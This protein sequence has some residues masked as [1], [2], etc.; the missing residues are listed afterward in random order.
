MGE[1]N[2]CKAYLVRCFI[3]NLR[4]GVEAMWY[5]ALYVALE[6]DVRKCV[7]VRTTGWETMNTCRMRVVKM[8]NKTRKEEY[9]PHPEPLEGFPRDDTYA[10]PSSEFE[11]G[12]RPTRRPPNTTD[13]HLTPRHLVVRRAKHHHQV[14]NDISSSYL[15]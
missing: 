6:S 1:A 8:R 14:L 12:F 13:H 3:H 10:L 2:L 7:V 15:E 11:A 9:P 5:M 4:C